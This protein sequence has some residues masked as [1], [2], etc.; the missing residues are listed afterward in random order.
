MKSND[1]ILDEA[2]NVAATLHLSIEAARVDNS[3]C[4]TD[5]DFMREALVALDELIGMQE[6]LYEVLEKLEEKEPSHINYKI[7][8]MRLWFEKTGNYFELDIKPPKTFVGYPIK[9]G[10]PIALSFSAVGYWAIIELV[11]KDNSMTITPVAG[12]ERTIDIRDPKCSSDGIYVVIKEMYE[13]FIQKV[14]LT[15]SEMASPL[16]EATK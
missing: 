14:D 1:D 3:C 16:E 6:D 5:A 10:R 11:L 8:F 9:T 4:E 2:E 15:Y 7:R 12:Q 13:E